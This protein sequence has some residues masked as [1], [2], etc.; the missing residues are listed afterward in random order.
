MLTISQIKYLRCGDTLHDYA[1]ANGTPTQV[2]GTRGPLGG[3]SFIEL[4]NGD[5]L[6]DPG[7][8]RVGFYKSYELTDETAEKIRD[9]LDMYKR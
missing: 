8:N 6:P 9:R 2:I 3:T 5:Y 1:Y 4:G 7:L